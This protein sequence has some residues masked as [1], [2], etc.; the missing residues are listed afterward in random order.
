MSDVKCLPSCKPSEGVIN[1]PSCANQYDTC[2]VNGSYGDIG[3]CELNQSIIPVG[4]NCNSSNDCYPESICSMFYN[5]TDTAICLLACDTIDVT[6]IDTTTYVNDAI[7]IQTNS[8]SFYWMDIC[9]QTTDC[10]D[11]N[12]VCKEVKNTSSYTENYCMPSPDGYDCSQPDVTSCD[13]LGENLGCYTWDETHG[14]CITAGT[15]PVGTECTSNSS[16]VPGSECWR[17]GAVGDPYLCTQLCDDNNLCSD[18]K[19]C[20]TNITARY[21][22]CR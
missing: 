14:Y 10:L 19:T 1:N 20:D 9:S 12:F 22:V 16:C 5:H 8:T 15:L 7:C 6:K 21:G 18:G 11:E 2:V 3:Y 17:I 4:E 13:Y